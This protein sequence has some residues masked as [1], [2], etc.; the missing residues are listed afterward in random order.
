M[1]KATAKKE[2]KEVKEVKEAKASGKIVTI[3]DLCEEYEVDP[4]KLRAFLRS[5]GFNAPEIKQEGFGP[6][7][8][9]EWDEK[10]PELKKIRALINE[11]L[12]GDDG[13][14]AEGEDE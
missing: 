2:V 3:K 6:R 4:R 5:K 7:S 14:E 1:A 10:S 9:Y 8:K 12:E 13:D 11:S